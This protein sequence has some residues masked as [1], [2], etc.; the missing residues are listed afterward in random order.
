MAILHIIRR[1]SMTFV[2]IFFIPHKTSTLIASSNFLGRDGY[3]IKE[4]NGHID[5]LNLNVK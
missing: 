3:F 5:K 4:I 2:W 1:V